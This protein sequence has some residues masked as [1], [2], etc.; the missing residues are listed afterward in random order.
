MVWDSIKGR[1]H[2]EPFYIPMVGKPVLVCAAEQDREAPVDTA[3]ALVHAGPR[4]ELRAYPATHFDL[5]TD[6]GIRDRA[7][8]DQLRFLHEHLRTSST[9]V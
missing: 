4:G 5:Y 1:L 6:P 9:V 7:L 2:L 3:R 8:A